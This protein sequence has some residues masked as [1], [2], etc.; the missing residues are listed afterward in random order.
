MGKLF[1]NVNPIN[2]GINLDADDF[3]VLKQRVF[4]E[5]GYPTVKVEITDSQFYTIIHTAA[6]WINLHSPKAVELSK[7]V[8]P[9][10]STYEFDELDR[11]ITGV[12]DIYCSIDWHIMGGAPADILLPE[13]GMIR[14][15]TDAAV[16]SEYVVKMAQHQMA[17]T[18][19]G[20]TPVGEAI[21]PKTIRVLP[22]PQ[23]ESM[24][25]F[26]V[27]TWHDE[28][29]GSY[30]DW[31]KNWLIRFC[32]ARAARI[33]GRVR[34]KYSGVTLPIGDLSS[35]GKDLIAESKE[36]EKELIDE[37]KARHKFAESYLMLG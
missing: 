7:Y 13:I 12:L 17:K 27:T 4:G 16:M 28:D 22:R 11:N 30:D 19:F 10:E 29:L 9:D 1:G 21:G 37:I 35:D 8:Y 5:Y 31:E 25:I 2:F 26:K 20:R 3:E 18:I 33:L 23:M 34:S 14:G 36:T 15:S 32:S 6:E 24:M